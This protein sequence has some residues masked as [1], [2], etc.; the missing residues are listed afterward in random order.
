MATK[1]IKSTPTLD[2]LAQKAKKSNKS[3]LVVGFLNQEMA[4]RAIKNEYGEGNIPPRPFMD[5]TFNLYS[6]K[7]NE[8]LAKLIVKNDY[9]LE[10][11]LKILGEVIRADIKK[12]I[13]Q[14]DLYVPNAP[15][16]V[17][18]KG[19]R[20]TPLIDTSEMRDSIEYDL[21]K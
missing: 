6:S 4:E 1:I 2:K 19:G 7:W 17:A 18:M 15:S 8:I 5:I 12:T 11:S 10:K 13:E 21:R 9:D 20:N 16:T 14:S 3:T